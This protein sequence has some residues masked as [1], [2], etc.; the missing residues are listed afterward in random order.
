MIACKPISDSHFQRGKGC[1]VASGG[2]RFG[3]ADEVSND[4]I[5][6][7]KALDAAAPPNRQPS[8]AGSD[9][10]GWHLIRGWLSGRRGDRSG[11]A[12]G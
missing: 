5:S 4:A 1:R 2:E 8:S 10:F 6:G 7:F 3:C 11:C 9:G 12:P